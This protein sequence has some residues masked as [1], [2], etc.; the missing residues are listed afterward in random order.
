M[1]FGFMPAHTGTFIRK[2][3]YD[4]YGLYD[5]T[6]KSAGDFE[7]LLRILYVNRLK[8]MVIDK[9]VSIM[10]IGGLSTSGFSSYIRTTK[11]IYFSLNKYNIYTNYIFLILRLPIKYIYNFIYM[12]LYFK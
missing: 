10:G 3:V 1:R 11:E 4:K 5:E 7:F 6:L 12:K 9:T 2:R 8:Y